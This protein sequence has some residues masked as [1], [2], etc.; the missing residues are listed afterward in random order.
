[1][2]TLH[3][4]VLAGELDDLG[5]G[6]IDMFRG[7]AN[8]GLKVALV[9]IVLY[10]LITRFSLKAGVGALLLMVLALG[11]YNAREDLADKVED[12]VKN[13]ARGAAQPHVPHHSAELA[14]GIRVYGL[15]GGAA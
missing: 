14:P 5:N 13:P 12:E 2:N 1:M 10:V 4:V 7:W 11:I 8:N 3:Q 15:T 6:W 9:A